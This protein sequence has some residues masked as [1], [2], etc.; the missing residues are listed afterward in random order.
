MIVLDLLWWLGWVWFLAWTA[1]PLT[2][3]PALGPLAGGLAWAVLAPWSSLLGMATVHRLLPTGA[4]GRHRMFADRGSV[5]WALK[6]W[7]PGIYLTVFQPV[8]FL[9]PGFQRVVLGA[10][11]A[12]LGAGAK[13][14]SR[15]ILR[16]PHRVRIGRG[17]VIGEFAHL[18]TSYQPRPNVLIVGEIDIGNDVLI[19]GYCHLAMGVRIGDGTILEHEVRVG[20]GC[21]IGAAA[22][23][24]HGT[25]LC[26]RSQVGAGATIGSR[27]LILADTVIP[28]GAWIPDGVTLGNPQP[29][30]R[31]AA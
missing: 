18:V 12:R 17:S 8:F 25:L 3:L 30:I 26:A 2:L 9:S 28:D 20:P 24:G 22:R 31:G 29:A 23:V 4:S 27:C 10:F 6:G 16:E 5:Q 14:T 21:L 15:T 11:Q 13:V 19:A 1:L 7:A